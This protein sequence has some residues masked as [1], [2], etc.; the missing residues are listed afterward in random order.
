MDEPGLAPKFQAIRNSF[1]APEEID[2]S[3]D[4]APSKR[5]DKLVP[6]HRKPVS[7]TLAAQAIGLPRIRREC[8]HFSHWLDRLESLP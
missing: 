5:I 4:T 1:A 3:P 8:P 2:D 6:G 7:G